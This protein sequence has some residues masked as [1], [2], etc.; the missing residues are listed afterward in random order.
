MSV[1]GQWKS[2]TIVHILKASKNGIVIVRYGPIT[3]L[4]YQNKI[5]GK[6]LVEL[7][8]ARHNNPHSKAWKRPL[9]CHQLKTDLPAYSKIVRVAA[10]NKTLV[11][12]N[13]FQSQYSS[14]SDHGLNVRIL[15]SVLCIGLYAL[16]NTDWNKALIHKMYRLGF[17]PFLI[18]TMKSMLR[19]RPF[20]NKIGDSL[21]LSQHVR[22]LYGSVLGTDFVQ[23]LHVSHPL[24]AA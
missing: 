20:S 19:S 8:V 21:P 10:I 16:F 9:R 1:C 18:R 2:D 24:R 12:L 5:Y 14:L 13:I 3:S 17:N 22:V 4:S 7:S 15:T 6:Q 23:Y 11:S